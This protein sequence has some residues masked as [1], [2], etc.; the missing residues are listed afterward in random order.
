VFSQQDFIIS[1][2]LSVL[3]I[4]QKAEVVGGW[5]LVVSCAVHAEFVRLAIIFQP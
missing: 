2:L 1:E 3:I 4:E 5:M